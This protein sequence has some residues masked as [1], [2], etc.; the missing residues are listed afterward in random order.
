MNLLAYGTLMAPDIMKEVSGGVWGSI[1]VILE[2]YRRYGIR[3]EQYPGI[4][5][6]DEGQVEG[7]LYL[8]VSPEAITRLDLF[9]GKT[10]SR[11]PVRVLQKSEGIPFEAMTYVV[12][13]EFVHLLTLE[14]WDFNNFVKNGKQLFEELYDGFEVLGQQ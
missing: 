9:E 8:D 5:R 7:V 1:P 10:Y 13:P 14:S 12:K 3:G 6:A 4:V 11:E 2:G